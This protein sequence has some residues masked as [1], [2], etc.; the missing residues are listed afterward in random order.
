MSMYI[1]NDLLKHLVCLGGDIFMLV[2][3]I[4]IFIFMLYLLTNFSNFFD[5]CYF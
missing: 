3:Y 5:I 1:N 4:Y 2:G